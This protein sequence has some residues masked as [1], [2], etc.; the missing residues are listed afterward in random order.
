MTPDVLAALHAAG[1]DQS[2]PWSAEEFAAFL[3]DPTCF[4]VGDRRCF[5]LGRVV[6]D[7]AELLTITTHPDHR[8]QGLARRIIADWIAAAMERGATRAFLEVAADNAPAR[9]LYQGCAFEEV[10]LRK[11]YY[12]REDGPAVDAVLMA[13]ALG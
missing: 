2:R 12:R 4:V 13:R 6:L 10:G 3:S 8:R 9:A 7:E 11:R 1:F 5:A